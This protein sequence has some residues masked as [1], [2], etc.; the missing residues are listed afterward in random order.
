LE[1]AARFTDKIF[2]RAWAGYSAQ[3]RF[4][5]EKARGPWVL[6][7]DAD[8]RVTPALQLEIRAALNAPSAGVC[9][10][11]IPFDHHFLGKRL[12]FGGV[13]GET[14]L[15]LFLKANA[16]YGNESVHEGIQVKG[17]VARLTN[18]IQHF[19]YR[20]V[21]DYLQKCDRYTTLIAEKKFKAGK[22]FHWWHHLRLPFEFVAR[23][24]FRLGVLDGEA[25][26]T[27]A[28]LSSY[29]VWL[30]FLKLRDFEG[31]L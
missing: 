31:S 18:P 19:S 9:G 3:K 22:R 20:D 29:Y 11:D 10:Y 23:Y 7:I 5:M 24:V 8:E 2:K 4:A 16:A 14:H 26:L 13:Q 1:I 30:K 27:Y 28:A 21:R 15:R 17:R 6:N 25:G 12:R